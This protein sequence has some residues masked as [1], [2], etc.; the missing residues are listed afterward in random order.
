MKMPTYTLK[1]TVDGTLVTR[2]LTFS[3]YEEVKAGTQVLLDAD[4]APLELVFNPGD[5]GFVMKDGASGGW[6]SKVGKEKKYRAGRNVDMAKR[7]KDH[8]FKS[9][10]IPNYQGQE[11]HSWSDVQDHV[12][13]TKGEDSASTYQP[14]VSKERSTS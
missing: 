2:R 1:N 12:R 13:T 8:V 10:L 9:R 6:A 14:L 4:G 3:T 11:A 5:I 7:E